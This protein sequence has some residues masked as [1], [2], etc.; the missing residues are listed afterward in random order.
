M[1][2]DVRLKC[3]VAILALALPMA[4][5]QAAINIE[6]VAVGNLGNSA[7]STGYGAV[8]YAYRIGKYEVTSGQY[9]AFLNAVAATD[10]Y[11]L[12][13]TDMNNSSSGCQIT[14]LGTSGS[15]TYDF[16]GRPIGAVSDWV[17]RPV[18]YV[19]WG[20]AVRFAN[21]LHNGQPTGAQDLSTTE[22]GA[23]LI[24]G[25]TADAALMSVTRKS[26]WTWS[27]PSE[28]EWY[29]AAYHQNNGDTGDYF[30]YPT[31]NNSAPSNDLDGGGNNAT[32]EDTDYTIGAPF[33]R[34]EGGAHSN[35]ASPYDTFDQGGNMWE[36]ND[37]VVNS[38]TARGVRSGSY[39]SGPN[40]M[41]ATNSSFG[42]PTR[43]SSPLGFRVSSRVPEPASVLVWAGLIGLILWRRRR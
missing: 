10:T 32:F 22:D 8:D 23:Y 9:A 42:V 41:R 16:S 6:T 40:H 26:N 3:L 33:W 4:A 5:A 28:D 7:D 2:Q 31:S 27:L 1:I 15:Y 18:N 29:K 43:A 24:S 17:D 19:D 38:G 13:N 20:D 39:F 11:G 37:A 14:Q 30:L 35:S 25:A 12:Y 36:W 21:W 34:T